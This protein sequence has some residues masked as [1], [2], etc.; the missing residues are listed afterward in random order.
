[1]SIKYGTGAEV[2]A[3]IN[4]KVLIKYGTGAVVEDL[5]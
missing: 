3:V 5:S 4:I 2:S 1:M